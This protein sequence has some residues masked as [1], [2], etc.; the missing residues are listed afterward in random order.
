MQ[1]GLLQENSDGDPEEMPEDDLGFGDRG[2]EHAGN[3]AILAFQHEDRC[4]ADQPGNGKLE[5]H[6][7]GGLDC[8][9]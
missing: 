6:T 1:D 5:Q 8:T 7:G 2:S 4:S 3:G 9:R